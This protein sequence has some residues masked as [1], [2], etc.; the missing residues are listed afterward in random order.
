MFAGGPKE[1]RTTAVFDGRAFV[2]AEP[3]DLRVG[4]TVYVTYY[5][6][7]PPITAEERAE[8]DRVLA[9]DGT[10]PPWATVEEALGRPK[11]EP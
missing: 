9:G 3:P 8:I 1:V 6:P 4:A 5:L 7:P 2:P 11:Y 10:P